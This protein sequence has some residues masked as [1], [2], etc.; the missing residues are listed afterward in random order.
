MRR[1]HHVRNESITMSMTR[2]ALLRRV[3]FKR[4]ELLRKRS[5]ALRVIGELIRFL[6]ASPSGWPFGGFTRND[7]LVLVVFCRGSATAQ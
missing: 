6:E 5:H 1:E 2:I 7:V 3:R 4:V